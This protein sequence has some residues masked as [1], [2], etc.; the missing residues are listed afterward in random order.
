MPTLQAQVLRKEKRWVQKLHG[1]GTLEQVY[2]EYIAR[3]K[4]T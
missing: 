1:T 3:K 4:G 2:I